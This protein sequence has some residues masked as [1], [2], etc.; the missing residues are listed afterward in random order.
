MRNRNPAM[1]MGVLI[2]TAEATRK[3]LTII[4]HHTRGVA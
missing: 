1:Y 4:N 3:Q 2:A